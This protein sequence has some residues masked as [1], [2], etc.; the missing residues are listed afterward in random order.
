MRSARSQQLIEVERTLLAV[1]HLA[2]EI[3]FAVG[4]HS[5]DIH[6]DGADPQPADFWMQKVLRMRIE[7]K[8]AEGLLR[9]YELM[10]AT[11]QRENDDDTCASTERQG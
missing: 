3:G 2:D 9:A 4:D 6:Y 8:R 5:D 10:R 11:D 1:S 7:L